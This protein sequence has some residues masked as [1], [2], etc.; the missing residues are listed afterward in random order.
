MHPSIADL[1]SRVRY[2]RP[3]VLWSAVV[4][5]VLLAVSIPLL[6]VGPVWLARWLGV[7]IGI[8]LDVFGILAVYRWILSRWF[9]RRPQSIPVT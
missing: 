7:G 8:A 4:L 2:L 5:V 6:F 9:L 3:L 1:Q